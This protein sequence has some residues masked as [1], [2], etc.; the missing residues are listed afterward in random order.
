MQA[1]LVAANEKLPEKFVK[2]VHKGII[3]EERFLMVQEKL[4]NK[5]LMKTQP[6]DEF[7]LRGI[8]LSPCCGTLMTAEWTKGNTKYYK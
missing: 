6:K 5:R 2:G 8:I 3:S 1:W 7:P 4:G